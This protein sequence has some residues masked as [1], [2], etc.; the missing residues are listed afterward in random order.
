MAGAARSGGMAGVASLAVSRTDGVD[1]AYIFNTR[2]LSS[3]ALDKL[4]I[5]LDKVFAA[6]TL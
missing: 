4:G 5:A 2:T 1:W 3:G 6:T